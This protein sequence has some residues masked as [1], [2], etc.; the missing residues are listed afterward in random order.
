METQLQSRLLSQRDY[1]LSKDGYYVT[2]HQ[3]KKNSAYFMHYHDYYEAVF[4]LGNQP[5]HYIQDGQSYTISKGDVILC[6]MFTEHMFDCK[7]NAGCE[8]FS[9]GV[10]Y[11]L[12]A[13]LSRDDSLLEQ[14]FDPYESVYPIFHPSYEQLSK[15]LQLIEAYEKIEPGHGEAVLKRAMICQIFA[16]LYA[17]CCTGIVVDDLRGRHIQLV[18]EIIHY[19]ETHMSEW[20]SLNDLAEAVSYSV[21]HVTKIFKEVTGETVS[22]YMLKRRIT[23]AKM[24]MAQGHS[25]TQAA[26]ESGF[27][28]YNYFFRAFK[29]VEG[30][31][32]REYLKALQK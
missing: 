22:Q 30:L 17:D 7:S 2:F 9:I 5:V 12:L 15:Y 20:F 27:L 6:G 26:E 1:T 21:A 16:N 3:E 29:K 28:N 8:R 23:Y 14:I 32:P 10:D 11:S 4:Y 25:I 19:T 18:S 31:G 24:K 13:G